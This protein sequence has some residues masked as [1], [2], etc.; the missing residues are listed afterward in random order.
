LAEEL[1][2]GRPRRAQFDDA[3]LVRAAIAVEHRR[4]HRAVM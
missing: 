2:S 1:T 4:F 3:H